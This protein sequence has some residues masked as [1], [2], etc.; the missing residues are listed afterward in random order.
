MDRFDERVID[1]LNEELHKKCPRLSF[2]YSYENGKRFIGIKN[3]YLISSIDLD[4][5]TREDIMILESRTRES[6]TTEYQNR[7][8]NTCL[9]YLAAM[10]ASKEQCYL[11]SEAIN[12]ISMYL[13]L[14][15]F[16]CEI[17]QT[18]QK[19]HSQPALTQA[20]CIEVFKTTRIVYIRANTEPYDSFYERLLE[21]IGEIQCTDLGGR[22]TRRIKKS[23]VR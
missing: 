20:Q 19:Y 12:P 18:G 17:R 9:R 22:K 2:V 11:L 1:R 16:D 13:M 6:K 3:R 4:E 7:G 8:F 23:S 5:P 15:L 21:K 14:K 10:I